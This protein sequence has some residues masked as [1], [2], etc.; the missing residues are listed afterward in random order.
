MRVGRVYQALRARAPGFEFLRLGLFF[1]LPFPRRKL[2][3]LLTN[4]KAVVA[5]LVDA[6]R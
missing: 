3:A 4:L 1:C 2:Y 5:E 6:Q